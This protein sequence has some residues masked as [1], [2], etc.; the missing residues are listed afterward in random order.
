MEGSFVNIKD[1]FLQ[2]KHA[3]VDYTAHKPAA[4]LLFSRT[5]R[6]RVKMSEKQLEALRL[7]KIDVNKHHLSRG[8]SM[9]LEF[10]FFSS[11]SSLPFSAV[12]TTKD[13]CQ[14]VKCSRHKVCVAQGYQRA[15]CVNRRKLEQ[16]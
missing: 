3:G 6:L 14:N 7:T 10:N 2:Y 9:L 12:D 5:S 1:H 8:G 11:S 4:A 15:M 16:K 13:P